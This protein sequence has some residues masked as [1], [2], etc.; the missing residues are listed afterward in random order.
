[1]SV[2]D[3]DIE[4]LEAHL[5]G[6]LSSAQDAVLRDRLLSE[7]ELADELIARRAD[8]TLRVEIFE[9]FEPNDLAVKNLILGVRKQITKDAVRGDRLRILRYIGSAAAVVVFSFTAGWLGKARIAT[10]PSPSDPPAAM[11][12]SNGGNS[13]GSLDFSG[14]QGQAQDQNGGTGTL[15]SNTLGRSLEN[16]TRRPGGYQVAL[17]DALGHV[18]AVQHFDTLEEAREFTEDVSRWQRQ[19]QQIRGAEPVVYKDQF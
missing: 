5:D 2:S 12:A 11:V 10:Q 8:R 9:S 15:I 3:S 7:L 19:Q 16:G 17:T 14:D 13:T 1:M 18:V 4:L 6:E